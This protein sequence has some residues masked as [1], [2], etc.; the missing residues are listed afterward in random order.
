[1]AVAPVARS[2]DLSRLA[3]PAILEALSFDDLRAA[4]IARFKAEWQAARVNDPT[5]PMYDVEVLETDPAMWAGRAWSYLRLLDRQRV[6]EAVLAV[7]A[8][9][10]AGP[11]LD[12]VVARLGVLRQVVTPANPLSGAPAVMETDAQLLRRYLYAFDRPSAGSPGCYLY[13]AFTAWPGMLDAVVIGRA[14]HGRRGDT[15]I[16]IAGPG[17]R[18]PTADELA[19]VRAAVTADGVKPEAVAV[20]VLGATRTLYSVD[21]AIDVPRGPDASLIAADAQARVAAVTIDR[22][23]I[24]AKVPSGLLTGAAY[25]PN[26]IEARRTDSGGDVLADPYAIPVCAGIS[27]TPEVIG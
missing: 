14:V 18:A 22:L 9:F 13:Q 25:G 23:Q 12:A 26:V 10:A 2:I 1:M 3:P 24:G 20:T 11:D 19:L 17:G 7:L 8:P 15:D 21:L 6:N 16:V 4:F 5:L 27:I